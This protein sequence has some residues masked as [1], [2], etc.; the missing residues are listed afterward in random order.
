[1]L[2]SENN[3]YPYLK[4][5][6]YGCG[7][8]L[9]NSVDTIKLCKDCMDQTDILNMGKDTISWRYT[10]VNYEGYYPSCSCIQPRTGKTRGYTIG[11]TE[12]ARYVVYLTPMTV[13]DYLLALENNAKP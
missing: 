12:Q 4:D 10:N 3:P 6:E 5:L 7:R 8:S 2:H 1:M 13:T 9:D 11:C